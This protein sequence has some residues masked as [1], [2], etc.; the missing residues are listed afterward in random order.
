MLW[1]KKNPKFN[2]YKCKHILLAAHMV[3]NSRWLDLRFFDIT[4][5]WYWHN[6]VESVLGILNFG[7]S[8]GWIYVIDY[9]LMILDSVSCGSQ[10]A[11]WSGE[12]TT[13]TLTTILIL[14]PHN[15]PGFHFQY[16]I[17]QTTLYHKVLR[18]RWF[19]ANVN[20]LSSFHSGRLG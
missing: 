14:Y 15:H 9:F 2:V 6:S 20:A 11:M 8:L 7:L 3:F 4:M 16:Y 17:R 12:S 10:P 19:G 1:G 13:D 5:V 18:V